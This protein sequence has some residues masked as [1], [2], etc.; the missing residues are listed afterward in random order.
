MSSNDLPPE[1]TLLDWVHVNGYM[2]EK[3][4]REVLNTA[5]NH[6]QQASPEL[7]QLVHDT[8]I[9]H[10]QVKGYRPRS[11]MNA[12]PRAVL[13][14]LGHQMQ[15]SGLLTRVVIWLWA[16]AEEDLITSFRDAA[17]KVGIRFNSDWASQTALEGFYPFEQIPELND[18]AEATSD[19]FI[20]R[21][22]YLLAALW[23]ST[24]LGPK[25]S[26][27][28]ETEDLPMSE[29][30]LSTDDSH[31]T[32][33]LSAHAESLK[34]RL[35]EYGQRDKAFITTRQALD[36]AIEAR[37]DQQIEDLTTQL[38][39][40]L[41]QLRETEAQLKAL[42]SQLADALIPELD[43]RPDLDPVSE[44]RR[45]LGGLEANG[46]TNLVETAE[47][48]LNSVQALDHY[49]KKREKLRG[50]IQEETRQLHQ[51]VS[52][53]DCLG[54]TAAPA[55]DSVSLGNGL[56]SELEANLQVL[57]DR[58]GKTQKHLAELR[59][60]A[61]S[62]IKTTLAQVRELDDSS[63]VEAINGVMLSSLSDSKLA[64][65]DVS[66]LMEVEARLNTLLQA[67]LVDD[68]PDQQ[69]ATHEIAVNLITDWDESA[70]QKLLEQ[71]AIE[72]RDV[73]A[74]LLLICSS[75]R[76]PDT[77]LT[78]SSKMI[79]CLIR[80]LETIS[81]D[82]SI[83]G[84]WNLLAPLFWRGWDVSETHARAKLLLLFL[85]A[86]YTARGRL[87][88]EFLWNL[89]VDSW[90][91]K[92]MPTWSEL[93]TAALDAPCIP[94]LV[95]EVNTHQ[96]LEILYRE[97]NNL[98]AWENGRYMR[99]STIKSRRHTQV[100]A[101]QLLP[102]LR[103]VLT[104]LREIEDQ[105]GT[106][107]PDQLIQRRAELDPLLASLLPDELNE[108]YETARLEEDIDD[109]ETY[110][111][112]KTLKLLHETA[113]AISIYGRAVLAAIT[114]HV[115]NSQALRLDLLEQELEKH[116][117]VKNFGEALLTHLNSIANRH[118]LPYWDYQTASS[119]ARRVVTSVLLGNPDLAA[120]LPRTI[121]KR[122]TEISDFQ[123][124]LPEVLDDITQPLEPIDAAEYLLTFGASA[125]ALFLAQMLPVEL[126]T[127]ARR[128]RDEQQQQIG[129]LESEILSLGGEVEDFRDMRELGRWP[130]L[131]KLLEERH[132]VLQHE[133]QNEIERTL[134]NIKD[135]R[136]RLNQVDDNLADHREQMPSEFYRIASEGLI[137]ARRIINQNKLFDQVEE[138]LN[139]LE[140]RTERKSWPIGE[141]EILVDDLEN[142]LNAQAPIQMRKWTAQQVIERIEEKDLQSLGMQDFEDS[143]VNTRYELLTNWQRLKDIQGFYT[144]DLRSE[145]QE[146]IRKV[147][148]YFDQ[149]VK[150][151]KRFDFTDGTITALRKLQF[152]RTKVLNEDCLLVSLP[153]ELNKS[154]IAEF[155]QLVE[156]KEWLSYYYVLLFAPNCNPSQ[157]KRLQSTY[158]GQR[159]IVI[160]E[161]NML[162]M[163]LSAVPLARLRSLMLN[164]R[165]DQAIKIFQENQIVDQRTSIFVGRKHL[166]DTLTS[167]S[168]N[169]A[170]YG[171][172]RI[173]KSSVLNAVYEALEKSRQVISHSFEGD[174]DC[175]DHATAV[176]LAR[177]LQ[178]PGHVESIDDFKFAMQQYLQSDEAPRVVLLLDEMDR[179]IDFNKPRHLL[180]ETLR[181]LSDSHPGQL[182]V[183][184]SGFMSLYDALKGR[185]QYGRTSDP[186][187]RM[188]TEV[189][190]DNLRAIEAESIPKEGFLEILGWEFESRSISQKIVEFTGGHPAFVQ[191]FC[192]KLQERVAVRGDRK[193][194]VQDIQE[195]FEDNN[196]ELS[197]IAYVKK[198]LNMNLESLGRYLTIW[199]AAIA[200]GSTGF[201]MDEIRSYA[202]VN[203]RE[204]PADLLQRS[205]EQLVATSVILERAPGVFDF[206]VPDYPRILERL[207]STAHLDELEA[208]IAGKIQ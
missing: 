134:Q 172:R 78:F 153:G 66:T 146:V 162:D 70:I 200:D 166:I 33:Q 199:L 176:K 82:G 107:Q 127:Q 114:E 38:P 120:R 13:P 187:Q 121:C 182:R 21:S 124:W 202:L 165:G 77:K 131:L 57:H 154:R 5:W 160:D 85:G 94:A 194:K 67:W 25:T 18:L 64:D 76:H 144:L 116:S 10:L 164:S 7:Q 74:L 101:T 150:M 79:D 115:N 206:T 73:E 140:Y 151:T 42:I 133:Q 148:T 11:I 189:C 109:S 205:I 22:R 98:L 142:Q 8:L 123:E 110:H 24:S 174:E 105:L 135:L 40:K 92:D 143:T 27:I 190:L 207:G 188:F 149:M 61:V 106:A 147:Y 3:F 141:I 65:L 178:L 15:Q 139:N 103:T 55:E 19:D 111:R 126:Q 83:Y 50:Q 195:V 132:D 118:E 20:E 36:K 180:I 204:V 156:D 23:L 152:P 201:T 16:E 171:G 113:E 45:W 203:G 159:L 75:M 104:K 69:I 54:G 137:I 12:P 43:V 125:Q 91:F 68:S 39:F 185:N 170:I 44:T 90:P 28:S 183:I 6:L 4:R 197:F 62:Q 81:T 99:V 41:K 198:T 87:P 208:E 14:A 56:V 186:W 47:L 184:V 52:D 89:N 17:Q 51:L 102:P 173:G 191:M 108:A 95:T 31:D 181:T 2:S 119:E 80:S 168:A 129:I 86:D 60:A 93:W 169:F 53:I 63:D 138:F 84:T 35:K 157:Y 158:Q 48:V 179:Y 88:S 145:E 136:R 122:V 177:R 128:L 1:R 155:E 130:L 72:G 59:E 34:E 29:P 46:I 163:A 49:D 196:P 192:A 32:V 9:D 26:L 112:R 97:A 71:L 96:R 30:T 167:S 58:L 117:E 161:S 100:L 193:I 175:S 37:D